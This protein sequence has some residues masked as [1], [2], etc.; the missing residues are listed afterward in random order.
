M[1]KINETAKKLN[2][3]HVTI[4]RISQEH[5][6]QFLKENEQPKKNQMAAKND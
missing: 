3:H 1:F 4:R 5:I 6:D 2:V